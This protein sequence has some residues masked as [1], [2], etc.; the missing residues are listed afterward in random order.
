MA[1]KVS[2]LLKET[3]SN[4]EAGGSAVPQRQSANAGALFYTTKVVVGEVGLSGRP[5]W[6]TGSALKGL[7]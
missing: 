1:P 7:A 4:R 3:M 6:F 2:H 5:V